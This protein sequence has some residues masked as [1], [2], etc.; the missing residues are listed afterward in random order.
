MTVAPAPR[1]DTAEPGVL[2]IAALS[3]IAGATDVISFVLLGGFF[4]AHITGNL[5]VI[6]A[7]MV[8]GT[9]PGLA[10][11]LAVPVFVVTTAVATYLTRRVGSSTPQMTRVLLGG[12]ALLLTAA[13]VLAFTNQGLHDP[14]AGLTVL[15]GVCAV[16]AMATQNTYLH[17]VPGKTYAS[18]VMTGNLVTVVIAATQ[19]LTRTGNRGAARARWNGGWPLLAGFVGGCLLGAGAAAVFDDRAAALPAVLAVMV[20]IAL[21]VNLGSRPDASPSGSRPTL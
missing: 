13:A 17:L 1:A 9:A 10:T 2:S 19:L 7:D 5:V 18:A 20:M 14:H 6:A 16:A 12:Q 8:A 4:S 21:S 15:I 3:V 11:W